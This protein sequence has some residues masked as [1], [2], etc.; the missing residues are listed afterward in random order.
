MPS[1]LRGAAAVF[2]RIQQG[3]S[4]LRQEQN[5]QN[6]QNIGTAMNL[7]GMQQSQGQHQQ[8]LGQKYAK[9]EQ[10][11][12]EAEREFQRKYYEFQ[13]GHANEMEVEQYK[14]RAMT[15]RNN[16]D[17]ARAVQTANIG[18]QAP[19]MNAQ[20]R[21]RELEEYKLPY[22]GAYKEAQTQRIYEGQI[23]YDQA[24]T[25]YTQTRNQYYPQEVGIKQQQADTAGRRADI[26]GQNVGSQIDTRA[27]QLGVARDRADV[28]AADVQFDNDMKT[29]DAQ[30]GG[31]A[32]NPKRNDAD[33]Y[34]WVASVYAKTENEVRKE[35][36]GSYYNE[37]PKYGTPAA[38]Q[39]ET[40]RRA[41]ERGF[42]DQTI[43]DVR[44]AG[45]EIKK[46]RT[47]QMPPGGSAGIPPPIYIPP[48]TPS[49]GMVPYQG[50]PYADAPQQQERA[51]LFPSQYDFLM[52]PTY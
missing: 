35:T 45:D 44:V 9:M 15:L 42:S 40:E 11:A 16:A 26:Y 23:P 18:A 17:N 21:Q 41:R 33:Y 1:L 2:P 20:L 31:A 6:Q 50:T 27:G 32:N 36:T 25:Q 46:A 29:Y 22:L 47:G 37:K 19:M 10:D 30:Y 39:A 8:N 4:L 52:N 12:Q 48:G 24:R 5:Q 7:L 51:P 34:K 38:I 28:Y 49:G 14:Q 13:Q 3:K 43:K